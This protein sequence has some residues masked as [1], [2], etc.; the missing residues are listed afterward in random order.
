MH[1]L[2]IDIAN[3]RHITAGDVCRTRIGGV[4]DIETTGNI[5]QY[6]K[7]IEFA[8][9][10]YHE[11]VPEGALPQKVMAVWNLTTG[12]LKDATEDGPHDI[13]ER[14]TQ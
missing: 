5:D 7:N 8:R 1:D 10:S 2:P 11:P 13:V 6:S 9:G 4:V 3:P 12:R 14:V